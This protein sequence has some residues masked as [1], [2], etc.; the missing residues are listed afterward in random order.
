MSSDIQLFK[1]AEEGDLTQKPITVLCVDDEEFNLDI[2]IRHLTKNDYQTLP[3]ETGEEAWDILD[4]QHETIDLVLLDRML[5]GIDGIEVL[6]RMKQDE[7]L[8]H[9]PVIMQTAAISNSDT[10]SG[11]DAGAYYYVKKPYD[12]GILLSIVDSAIKDSQ[13][14][15]L[16][17]RH[18]QSY[19]KVR[20]LVDS[21]HFHFQTFS[22]ARELAIHLAKF[23]PDPKRL[24]VALT[25]LLSNAIEH[26]NYEIGFE[27]KGE[28][29]RSHSYKETLSQCK[30]T[31]PYGDRVVQVHL[32]KSSERFTVMI[33]DE[34]PGF[35]WKEYM[36]FDPIRVTEPNGR[37][38]PT[39]NAMFEN[40]LSFNDK[41]NIAKLDIDLTQ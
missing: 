24:T 4:K 8:K 18:F 7:R 34:G 33:E 37:G 22:E 11:I 1:V 28:L 35:D 27:R 6:T 36:D 13:Q 12:A 38:L 31:S 23:H 29:L 10:K 25:S 14:R 16:V 32:D 15:D 39:I 20:K 30:K 9:I 5:P 21:E 41:G 26:G 17:E 40:A 19:N 3:A 2:L